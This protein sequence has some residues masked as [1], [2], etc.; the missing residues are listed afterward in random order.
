MYSF[1]N[2][3]TAVNDCIISQLKKTR[4]AFGPMH[5][6]L[7]NVGYWSQTT[8]CRLPPALTIAKVNCRTGQSGTVV[9]RAAPSTENKVSR[10]LY[11]LRKTHENAAVNC[12]FF[13]ADKLTI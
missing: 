3:G 5:F 9:T 7:K 13:A 8:A 6:Y 2:T 11:R 4:L 1:N 10:F 12:S